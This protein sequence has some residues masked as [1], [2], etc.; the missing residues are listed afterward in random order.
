MSRAGSGGIV[1]IERDDNVCRRISQHAAQSPSPQ[2]R[3]GR[4]GSGAMARF[5]GR[6]GIDRILDQREK[7]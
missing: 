4:L 5:Q 2:R 3:E 7:R 6:W 1:G